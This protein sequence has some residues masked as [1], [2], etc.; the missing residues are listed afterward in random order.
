[1]LSVR[2]WK[3]TWGLCV[4]AS[5]I[6]SQVRAADEPTSKEEA[7][8]LLTRTFSVLEA[9]QRID[10]TQPNKDGRAPCD[11]PDVEGCPYII[12]VQYEL[13]N[14]ERADLAARLFIA[15]GRPDCNGD[16]EFAMKHHLP[17]YRDMVE[18]RDEAIDECMR[19]CGA[20]R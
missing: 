15:L 17:A 8:A 6:S 7:C 16:L 3:A 12:E 9:R 13:I 20:P 4:V 10:L 1:M 5:V 19:W 2:S 14:A 11:R 18:L